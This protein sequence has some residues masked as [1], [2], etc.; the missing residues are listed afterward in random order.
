VRRRKSIN[1]VKTGFTDKIKEK[2]IEKKRAKTKRRRKGEGEKMETYWY[3]HAMHSQI[4]K[5]KD[6]TAICYY[7]Y[8]YLHG[9]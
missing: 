2:V 1:E 6:S 4:T 8:I 3:S 5:S 7:N 9:E